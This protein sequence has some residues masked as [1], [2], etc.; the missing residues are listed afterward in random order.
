MI[1]TQNLNKVIIYAQE[2]AERL[3]SKRI[4]PDHLLLGILRLGEGSA[5]EVLQQT[6]IDVAA[7]KAHLEEQQRGNEEMIEPVQRSAQTDRILRIAEGISREYMAEAVGTIH[8]LLAILRERI[9]TTA[10]YL[11]REWHISF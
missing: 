6:S 11:E 4:E 5:F 9:N 7:A 10:S 2:E 3:V 8:L 1:V